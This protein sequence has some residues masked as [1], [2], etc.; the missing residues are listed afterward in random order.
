MAK[1]RDTRALL[2]VQRAYYDERAPDY[3]DPSKPPDR[4]SR[5]S[6]P[7]ALGSVLIDEFAPTG[8]VLELACGSGFCTRE[9]VRH[10]TSLTALDGSARML[11]RARQA[12]PDPKVTFILADVFTWKPDRVY[13]AVV[14]SFWLS[15][16]P[17][18]D[19]FDEFW[20]RVGTCLKPGGRVCFIDEDDRAVTVDDVRHV[21]GVPVA[22]RTLADGREFDIVKA[23][24]PPSELE[25]R[26]AAI[27][28]EISVRP[29]GEMFLFG[30]GTQRRT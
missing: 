27:G 7:E 23:F 20:R 9:I 18:N 4:K 19:Q 13:D 21:D 26:L 16:V 15:H 25:Q 24:W 8:D 29:V 30:T 5:S 28:W 14:F 22:R 3:M 2:E 10:A 11:D 17:P 1:S 6:L 12:V